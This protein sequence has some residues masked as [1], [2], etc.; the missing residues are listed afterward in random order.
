MIR[1]FCTG[2]RVLRPAMRGNRSSAHS[3]LRL[4]ERN[5]AV[6]AALTQDPT[7]RTS[8]VAATVWSTRVEL[9]SVTLTVF[10][11]VFG[12]LFEF[13]GR[14]VTVP[15]TTMLSPEAFVTLPEI[16][17]KSVGRFGRVP[18]LGLGVPV[19]PLPPKLGGA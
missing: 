3:G 8:A 14:W 10:V 11:E 6:P 18:P 16:E 19:P 15:L 4:P 1:D 13:V 7:V 9:V 5:S 12:L 2:V 17:L